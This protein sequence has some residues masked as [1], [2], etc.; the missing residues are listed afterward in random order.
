M[1]LFKDFFGRPCLTPDCDGILV[2][3]EIHNESEKIRTLQVSNN[4]DDLRRDERESINIF[5]WLG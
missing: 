1:C 4:V 2:R 3:I 5:Y